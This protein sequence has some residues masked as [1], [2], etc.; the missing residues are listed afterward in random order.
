LLTLLAIN[1]RWSSSMACNNNNL[2]EVERTLE[3]VCSVMGWLT[4]VYDKI[5]T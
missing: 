2:K 4:I 1:Q 3:S 5:S